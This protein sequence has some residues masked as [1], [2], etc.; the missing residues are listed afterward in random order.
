M[1]ARKLRVVTIE[2]L[3]EIDLAL[4]EIRSA[5]TR[6]RN[7]GARQS[8][9]YLQAALKSAEGARNHAR[10]RLPFDEVQRIVRRAGIA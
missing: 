6:L 4:A 5:R 8:A 3:A 10:R 2:Q 7:A 9:N 1:A